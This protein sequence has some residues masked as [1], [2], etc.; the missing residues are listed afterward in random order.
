MREKLFTELDPVE[1]LEKANIRS[2]DVAE[3]KLKTK[4]TESILKSMKSRLRK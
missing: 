3:S 4:I 2:Y 1:V